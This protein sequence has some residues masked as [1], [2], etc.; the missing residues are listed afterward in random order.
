MEITKREKAQRRIAALEL[1]RSSWMSHWQDINRKLLPRTGAFFSNEANKGNRRNDGILDNTATRALYT[2]GAG[3]QSGLTS[4][5]RP[6][7]KLETA[8]P[9]LMETKAVSSWL[10]KVTQRMLTVFARSNTYRSLHLMYEEL[11]GYGTA[12]SVVLPDFQDVIRFYPMT[13]GEYAIS[14]NDRGEV[15]TLARKFQMTVGQIVGR[16]VAKPDG[17]MD[18]AN[19][20]H[21]VKNLWDQHNVDAWV[22][23]HQLMQ[24]RKDRDTRKLDARNMPFESLTIE[25]G[26][27]DDKLLKE[28]GY[29]R[30]PALTPRWVV[31][32]QDIYGSSCPGMVALGDIN[33][34]QHEQL[35][36]AQGIDY[37]TK[38]PLQVPITLKNTD[39]DFLP[40]GVTYV[41]QT[42]VQNAVRTAFDVNLNM[43]HLLADINDVRN[44]IN[45]A[46]YSDLFLFLSNLEGMRGKM[47][48]R[49][50][51][52]IHE[53]K[54]LMLGPVVENT[55]NELLDPLADITFDACMEAGIL[56]PPPPELEGQEFNFSFVGILSQAQRSVSMSGVDRI[57][58]ATAS[59]AAAKGDPSVWDKIDTDQIIDKAAGYLGVDPEII[60]GD[61]QV[62]AI[63]EQRA[64]AQA[65]QEKAAMAQAAAATAKDLAGAD[66]SGNNALTNV[67]QTFSGV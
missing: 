3:M 37:Q 43:E 67:V 63:R 54:L 11:G 8:D 53:E 31:S 65:A 34:L 4:P 5:A 25:A 30:F 2:L 29:R 56:P 58:G 55:E 46:F 59:M 23:V 16:F 17:A 22:T 50:V 6:W 51:A 45:G 47:T 27:N 35:R 14:T 48:A 18:W 12:G 40:G 10:D 38:P 64:Q 13:I 41:D 1:E 28:S 62:R 19:A 49:E 20:S 24:P 21:T 36:K 39:S 33:Q 26:G 44:R 60:R 9:E 66:M 52:E 42:G 7:L 61:D 32:G 15:D 57:V